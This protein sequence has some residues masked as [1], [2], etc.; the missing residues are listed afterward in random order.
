MDPGTKVTNGNHW[1]RLARSVLG[2]RLLHSFGL[3]LSL[4]VLEKLLLE[5]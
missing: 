1:R 2:V 5:T 3:N 4:F